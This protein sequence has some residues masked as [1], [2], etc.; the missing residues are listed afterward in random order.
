MENLWAPWRMA[1]ITPKDEQAKS[2]ECIFCSKPAAQDDARNHIVY[3]GERCFMMLNLYPYN[4]GHLMIA[5]YRHVPSITELEAETLGDLM[6]Q[7]QLA[8]RALRKL[9]APDGFN[10]GINEGKVAGAGFAGHV[11]LHIVPRWLGDTNFMPVIADVK[12][13]PEHLDNVYRQLK[14]TLATLTGA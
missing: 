10:L 7:A 4:N 5:P 13:I 12:V 11:H 6:A 2:D 9:M 3:R 1:Y 14:E 8:L